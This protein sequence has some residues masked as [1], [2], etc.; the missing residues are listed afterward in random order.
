MHLIYRTTLADPARETPSYV[1]GV[2]LTNG[3]IDGNFKEIEMAVLTLTT[4]KANSLSPDL[5]GTPTA[6][7]AAV[8]TNTLQIANTAFVAAAFAR[9]D[10]I[11]AAIALG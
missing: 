2:G 7:T 3:E 6:P 8:G 10:P 5:T 9:N 1:K 4:G 11:V